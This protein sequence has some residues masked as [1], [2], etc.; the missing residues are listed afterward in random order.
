MPAAN[1]GR[2]D[3][4]HSIQG[5]MLPTTTAQKGETAKA[6]GGK[7]RHMAHQVLGQR[8]GRN[9]IQDHVWA[10]GNSADAVWQDLATETPHEI[11][12]VGC[13]S[14]RHAGRK[15]FSFQVVL[16]LTCFAFD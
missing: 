16:I 9:I 15:S 1:P 13:L 12:E 6:K 5:S 7:A 3:M 2:I 14:S 4:P 10:Y 8:A 11:N